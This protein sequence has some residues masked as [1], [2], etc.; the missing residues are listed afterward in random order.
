MYDKDV[1]CPFCGSGFTG[2][3]RNKGIAGAEAQKKLKRHMA[4]CKQNPDSR[5]F[6]KRH[7]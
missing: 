6:K 2:R 3:G 1:T 5:A 4:I 7:K